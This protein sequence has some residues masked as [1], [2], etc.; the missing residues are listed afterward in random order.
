VKITLNSSIPESKRPQV[1]A[2]VKT[3]A[4]ASQVVWLPSRFPRLVMLVEPGSSAE[5]EP[6]SGSIF[7]SPAPDTQSLAAMT[8]LLEERIKKSLANPSKK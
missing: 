6:P 2:L 7:D 8:E 5:S 1:E 4:G 3:H